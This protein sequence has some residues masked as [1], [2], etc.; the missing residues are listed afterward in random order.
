MSPD[1]G[2]LI[3]EASLLA[4]SARERI[5]WREAIERLRANDGRL[6]A[7]Y[8]IALAWA[9]HHHLRRAHPRVED[10]FVIGSA[11]EEN[12]R[13]SSD[14]DLVILAASFTAEEE[15]A[16]DDINR[17]VSAAYRGIVGEL[18][19]DFALLDLHLVHRS[20]EHHPH[21]SLLRASN[22]PTYRLAT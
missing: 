4:L 12:A 2:R 7:E 3:I 20:D 17:L 13:S 11:L 14:L 5:P 1:L 9:V 15:R 8:R 6:H 18:P 19:E 21:R 22:A 10:V 16:L